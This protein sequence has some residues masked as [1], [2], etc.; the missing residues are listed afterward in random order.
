MI[1]YSKHILDNGLTLLCHTDTGTPFVS[2]NTLYKVGSRDEDPGKTGFAHLF[3]HL[4][5]GGSKNAPDFDREVQAAGGESNAF[6][7]NDF[8]NYYITV[9]AGNIETALWLEADRMAALN[10]SGKSL[11]TQKNVVTEEYKQR[12]LNAPYGDVWLALR[13][14]AYRVHPYRWPTIGS[15]LEH[16][17]RATL[18]DVR[19]FFHRFYRPD[20]AI[21][22]I[23][24]NIGE[25]EALEKVKKWFG[26]ISPGNCRKA[27]LPVEPEQREARRLV[28]KEKSV[29]ADMLF[30]AYHMGDR[31]SDHFYRCDLISDL[32]SNGQSS[33]LYLRLVKE[34]GIFSNLDAYITGESDPGLFVCS[35]T[36]SEGIGMETAEEALLE[37]LGRF[38]S[39]PIEE[40]ELRKVINKMNAHLKY[41]EINYQNKAN[42]MA[43]FEFLGASELINGEGEK[44][45][46]ITAGQL[47]ATARELFRPEN[48]STLHYLKKERQTTT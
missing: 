30:K 1:V 38:V 35:G 21:I 10:I 26:A 16:I 42:T 5:F 32:L 44:Y 24:G 23:S 8:T 45:E 17:E 34:K 33:R 43:F 48:C 14:L 15:S 7:T 25:K 47:Q 20:N 12:Y 46:E 9:P 39:D 18:E 40:R 41:S 19:D 22:S 29:P 11:G 27:P 37:E 31:L 6:T 3:E 2:V 4:M 28:M 13:P 36:L